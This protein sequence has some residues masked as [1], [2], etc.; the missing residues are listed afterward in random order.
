MPHDIVANLGLN[1]L[2]DPQLQ[3]RYLERVGNCIDF[4]DNN[5]DSMFAAVN[6]I[7]YFF[8]LAAFKVGDINDIDN[9]RPRIYLLEDALDDLFP[10]ESQNVLRQIQR[11][12]SFK[13]G[14]FLRD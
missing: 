14:Y 10:I 7:I 4:I 9:Y 2:F 3:S 11:P 6:K 13:L 8:D 12:S 5:K 1:L